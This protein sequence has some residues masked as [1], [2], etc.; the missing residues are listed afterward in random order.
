MWG[1]RLARWGTL[2]AVLLAVPVA[3][4]AAAAFLQAK[5]QTEM[6]R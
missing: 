3:W 2:L 4:L 5:P 6:S 1:S